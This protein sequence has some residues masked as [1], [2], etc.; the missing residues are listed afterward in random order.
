MIY[1]G[2]VTNLAVPTNKAKQMKKEKRSI[3]KNN[4]NS[5]GA[6]SD[7][8]MFYQRTPSLSRVCSMWH[9]KLL[10]YQNG[11][12]F[13]NADQCSVSGL[14]LPNMAHMYMKWTR[15]GL[16]GRPTLFSFYPSI[17]WDN[18]RT[19]VH[20]FEFRY[21]KKNMESLFTTTTTKT[22]LDEKNIYNSIY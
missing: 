10:A 6:H 16:P 2:Y 7:V 22:H 21:A 15:I 4:E 3:L 13:R 14:S 18:F 5:C 11:C 17:G 12:L 19:N 9:T 8:Q 1:F 20:I